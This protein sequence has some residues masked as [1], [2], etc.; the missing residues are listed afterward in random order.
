MG[1]LRAAKIAPD[2][3][4][5]SRRPRSTATPT[6]TS[7]CSAGARPGRRSTPPC[8]ANAAPATKVAWI[9]LDHLN[10]LP[11]DLGEKLGAVRPGARPR[12]QPGPARATSSAASTSSTPQSVS[13]V[14]GL[15]FTHQRDRSRHRGRPRESIMSDTA[16]T[17]TTKKDWTS[18]QEVRWCPGL[19][20]LR[21]PARRPAADARA[22]HRP[23][24]HRVHLRHR[25]FEPVPVLHEHL[26]HALDPRPRAGDRHRASP[27]PA[28]TST[29]GSSPATATAC[30]SVATT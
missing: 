27:W 12:A 19:R 17:L 24:E 8:S 25:L 5:L 29:C 2:R 10:P 21:H 23:R 9:H 1:D 3:R 20:R 28:P 18:D 30:R 15:P 4:R 6:P 13:K 16:V 14:A 22:R 7:A 11:N 26:R